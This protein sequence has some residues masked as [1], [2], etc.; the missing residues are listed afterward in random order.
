MKRYIYAM[1]VYKKRA[2]RQLTSYSSILMEHIIKLLVYSDIRPDDVKGWIHTLAT[3]ISKVDSL[4]IKPN[5]DKV[6]EDFLMSTLFSCM[7][8]ELSDYER[9]LYSF[10]ADNH[11]GKFN[12]YSHG[13]YPEFEVTDQLSE[14]LM[15]FCLDIAEATIPLLIDKQDHDINEYEEVITQVYNSLV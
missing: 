15:N 13:S 8:D 7:G 11:S 10:L 6:S 2:E 3:W 12:A 9:E 14:D 1:S 4:M 5:A